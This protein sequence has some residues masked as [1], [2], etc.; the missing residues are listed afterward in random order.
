MRRSW[1]RVILKWNKVR[2]SWPRDFPEAAHWTRVEVGLETKATICT[3]WVQR[4]RALVRVGLETKP[5]KC[6]RAELEAASGCGEKGEMFNWT[7]LE[8]KGLI[9]A[10][11]NN[12]ATLLLT[13]PRFVF[14]SSAKD[15][16]PPIS[17]YY[18]RDTA[19]ALP[20]SCSPLV[21]C[22]AR[23]PIRKLLT[24]E[25]YTSSLSSMDSD[26]EAFSRNPTHG[27]VAALACQLTAKTNYANK[28]FL[29][30]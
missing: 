26:L 18:S 13:I 29:S 25:R 20:Q 24:L 4:Q 7:N 19:I 6:T 14:K 28:Q 16:S 15:L 21:R 2:R 23:V 1:P 27:S 3:A 11:R 12:K 10:D 17:H 9:S 8:N 5:R 30:Y 22:S